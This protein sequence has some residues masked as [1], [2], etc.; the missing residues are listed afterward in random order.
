M[1]AI[2]ISCSAA[3]LDA[4]ATSCCLAD[5]DGPTPEPPNDAHP[6]PTL[7]RCGRNPDR[8]EPLRLR[9]AGGS[10]RWS[11]HPVHQLVVHQKKKYEY[12]IKAYKRGAKLL[13]GDY[14]FAF[15]LARSI[16]ISLLKLDIN[17][18]VA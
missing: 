8:S 15:E 11:I 2:A 14:P 16:S 10:E 12:A 18:K 6:T 1:S 3:H 17:F 7:L 5:Q 9:A 4:A 13:N